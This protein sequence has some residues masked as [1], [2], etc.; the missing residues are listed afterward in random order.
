MITAIGF[1]VLLL[2]GVPIAWVL[3]LTGV[4]HILSSGNLIFMDNLA[5]RMFNGVNLFGLLAV[6]LFLFAGE[7]MNSGGLTERLAN[8]ARSLVGHYRG[9]LAYVTTL[10]AMFL[11]AIVGSAT[12]ITAVGCK[13]L[14][15]EMKKDGYDEDFAVGVVAAASILGPI[16]PPS[17][18]FVV[19]GVV[20]SVSI[21]AM[22]IGGIIPGI[23]LGLAFMAVAFVISHKKQ[24]PILPRATFKDFLSGLKQAAPAL[25]LPVVILGG[26][27]CGVF[28]PTECAGMAVVVSIIV[29]KFIYKDLQ[30]RMIPEMLKNT[31]VTTAAVLII[32][33]TA[34]I[35]GWTLA[36]QQVPQAIGHA[37]LSISSNPYVILLIINV[38][39]LFVGCIMETFAAIVI[40]VPVFAPIITQLGIDPLHFGL[41]MSINLIVGLITPPVGLCLF[42]ASSMSDVDFDHMSK[43]IIPYV[44]VSI[45]VVLLITYVPQLTLW[46]PNL[47]FN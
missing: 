20:A 30:W 12:A 7:L 10:V 17:M 29:G 40:L 36:I 25:S 42:V 24:Y 46:L 41:M 16:I 38:F 1:I 26:M 28:T 15:P 21:G 5:Q 44:L 47:V 6:P 3:G 31:A 19:Y 18:I 34:N 37:L 27:L 45:I 23:I 43:V 8:F 35:F 22:F 33:A 13:T 2:L 9:G 11:A 4:I 14:V 32:I 39:L